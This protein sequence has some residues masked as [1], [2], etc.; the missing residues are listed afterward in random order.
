MASDTGTLV[1]PHII[2]NR[3]KC[4]IH[5]P[6]SQVLN[7]TLVFSSTSLNLNHGS[8][9]LNGLVFYCMKDCTSVTE[10]A[11]EGPTYIILLQEPNCIV[12]CSQFGQGH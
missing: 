12:V 3:I 1:E 5:F 4:L 6:R 8:G 7:Q 9:C 11:L 10:L 2:N